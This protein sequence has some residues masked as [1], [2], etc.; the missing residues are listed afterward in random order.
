METPPS[1]LDKLGIQSCPPGPSAGCLLKTQN[2]MNPI[3]K[4][5]ERYLLKHK[6]GEEKYL[7][8]FAELQ[9]FCAIMHNM[10]EGIC[11]ISENNGII[12][13]TN[14][15]FENMFGYNPGELLGKHVST[16]NAPTQESPEDTAKNIIAKLK[17]QKHWQGE[18]K[19]IKKNGHP[20]YCNANVSVFEH[21]IYGRV[22]ISVHTDI[23]KQKSLEIEKNK[24]FNKLHEAKNKIKKLKNFYLSVHHAKKSKTTMDYGIILNRI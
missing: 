5:I 22:W 4:E 23:T 10:A 7:P 1:L 17:K 21:Y 18:I 9:L 20:F 14:P 8:A 2:I 24:A 16:I 15:R 3:Y 19:N 12:V 11:L 6:K 13:Y